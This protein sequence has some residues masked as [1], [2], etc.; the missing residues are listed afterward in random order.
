MRFTYHGICKG[1]TK[2]GK[3]CGQRSVY[4]NG[5]CRLHGGET[6]QEE[7]SAYC[8]RMRI[9]HERRMKKIRRRLELSSPELGEITS[10]ALGS[11][12]RFLAFQLS[13]LHNLSR[14]GEGA[15]GPIEH[16]RRI[17]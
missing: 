16:A 3:P 1:K 8:Q 9:K 10:V 4:G 14:A 6:T 15:A 11:S 17:I 7:I 12:A 13:D 5:L 2:T